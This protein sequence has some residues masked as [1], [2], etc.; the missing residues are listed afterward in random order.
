M[1]DK[2]GEVQGAS[3]QPKGL[4]D[5]SPLTVAA[6]KGNIQAIKWLHNHGATMHSDDRFAMQYEHIEALR[7]LLSYF[8][9][10]VSIKPIITKPASPKLDKII[11][12]V[13]NSGRA[14]FDMSEAIA[15]CRSGNV[16]LVKAMLS[17]KLDTSAKLSADTKYPEQVGH[18]L[19]QQVESSRKQILIWCLF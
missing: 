1:S 9:G 3:I 11:D 12:L 17:H 16:N 7:L 5:I 14:E 13:F 4:L 8:S 18:T 2:P 19:L 10:A 6:V 15:A